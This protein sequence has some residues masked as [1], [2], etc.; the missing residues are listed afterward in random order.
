VEDDSIDILAV[1]APACRF[2]PQSII[3]LL[4]SARSSVLIYHQPADAAA[5]A[6]GVETQIGRLSVS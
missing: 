3:D 6:A 5:A 2:M 4:H 1:A